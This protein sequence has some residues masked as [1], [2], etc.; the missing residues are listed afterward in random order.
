MYTYVYKYIYICIHVCTYVYT[1]QVALVVQNLPANTRDGTEMGLIPESERSPGGRAQ[2]PTPVFL[3]GESHGQRSLAGCSP[4]S[5][6]ELDTNERQTLSLFFQAL[7]PLYRRG[8]WASESCS[9]LP[10]ARQLAHGAAEFKRP[11]VASEPVI[12]TSLLSCLG[13]Q[14]E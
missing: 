14:A 1:S 4:W 3:L 2:Q 9:N 10:K 12:A 13:W 6:K 8:N 11:E 5:H 7:F